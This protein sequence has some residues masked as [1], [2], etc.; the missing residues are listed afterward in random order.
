MRMVDDCAHRVRTGASR[1][2]APNLPNNRSGHQFDRSVRRLRWEFSKRASTLTGD[3]R[4][5]LFAIFE[6]YPEIGVA[7]QGRVRLYLRREWSRRSGTQVA[8]VEAPRH[9]LWPRRVHPHVAKNT[10]CLGGADPR[11]FRRPDHQR[12]R[13][14]NHEQGQGHQALRLRLPQPD[15]LSCEGPTGVWSSTEARAAL[16]TVLRVEPGFAPTIGHSRQP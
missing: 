1:K 12:L 15:A 16:T 14:G 9:G 6:L 7:A 10:W 5:K 11:L 4:R 8:G 13:R 3:E 2:R